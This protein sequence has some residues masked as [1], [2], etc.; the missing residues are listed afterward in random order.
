VSLSSVLSP[1]SLAA[2]LIVDSQFNPSLLP[3]ATLVMTCPLFTATLLHTPPKQPS[4]TYNGYEVVKNFNSVELFRMSIT[5]CSG[6]LRLG[7]FKDIIFKVEDIMLMI[8]MCTTIL[9][10]RSEGVVRWSLLI[11]VLVF[12][13]RLFIQQ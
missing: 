13:G 7:K 4:A 9:S 1:L 11:W 8:S 12:G 10:Y 3:R 6:S 5:K 2:S